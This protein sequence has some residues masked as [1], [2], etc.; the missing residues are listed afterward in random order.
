MNN[1]QIL[2]QYINNF[3]RHFARYMR[4]GIGL[5]CRVLPVISSGAILE[6]TIGPNISNSD[7][8]EQPSETVNAALSK[9]PQKAFGGNLDNFRFGGTNVIMEEGRIILIKGADEPAEWNDDA[10]QA[11]VNRILPRG[12]G[13]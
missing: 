3:R 10:A 8:F 7:A 2:Q 4:Q 6:F 12:L 11:D 13:G 1:K 9:I 5:A